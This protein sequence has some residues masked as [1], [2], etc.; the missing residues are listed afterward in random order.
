MPRFDRTGPEGQGPRTGRMMG[1]CAPKNNSNS[2]NSRND[3]PE[4]DFRNG[5]YG[6]GLG[7]GYGKGFGRGFGRGFGFGRRNG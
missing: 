2:D 5:G 7:R 1:K 4:D 6:R 3:L